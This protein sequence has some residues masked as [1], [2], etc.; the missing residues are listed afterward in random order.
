MRVV[1]VVTS[2]FGGVFFTEVPDT[3]I[4]VAKLQALPKRLAEVRACYA[5]QYPRATEHLNEA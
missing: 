2:G 3:E 4:D 5:N 1:K